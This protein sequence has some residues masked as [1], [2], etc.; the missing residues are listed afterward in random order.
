M[1][2]VEWECSQKSAQA[3]D[4]IECFSSD[5]F[6]A[7]FALQPITPWRAFV[8]TTKIRSF[9]ICLFLTLLGATAVHAAPVYKAADFSGGL[10]SVTST[11]VSR[12]NAAGIN[13]ISS[14][15]CYNCA[16]PTQ[17][18]G[19]LVFDAAVP[20]PA[21]GT[22]NVFSIGAIPDVPNAA[23]FEL[24]I[25]GLSFRFGDPGIQGGPAIQYRNG[26]FNGFFFAEDFLSPNGTLLSFSI[27]GGQFSL[28]NQQ[29]ENLLTGFITTGAAGLANIRDYVPANQVPEPSS[30]ALLGMALVAFQLMRKPVAQRMRA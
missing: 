6:G 9:L 1:R 8:M 19:H 5:V 25:D 20:I 18:S 27:Q 17:V 22:A 21:S 24:N 23:I 15:S 2:V 10:F 4:S 26:V 7:N 12:L 13:T 30:L 29:F 3:I 16:A 14:A 28:V 11:F